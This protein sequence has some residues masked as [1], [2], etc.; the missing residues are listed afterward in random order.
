MEIIQVF[1]LALSKKWL[2]NG[3]IESDIRGANTFDSPFGTEWQ[4]ILV[5]TG[6]YQGEEPSWK[7]NFIANDVYDAVEWAL[8]QSNW[9]ESIR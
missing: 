4:S 8:K 1:L 7:P 3:V 9:K 6:V 2:A 5:R